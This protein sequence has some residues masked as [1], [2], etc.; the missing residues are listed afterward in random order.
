MPMQIMQTMIIPI[1]KNAKGLQTDKNNY[2]PIALTCI[3]SKVLETFILNKFVSN[4]VTSDF[5]FGFRPQ[6]ATD[7]CI[8]ALKEVIDFYTNNSS[9]LYIC[10]LDASKAFDKLNH[11]IL[12]DKLLSCYNIPVFIVRI[13]CYWFCMQQ[14]VVK[15][16]S[17]VSVPFSVLNGVRQGGIL[18]PLLFNIDID[19]L[20]DRLRSSKVGCHIGVTC[21]NLLFYAGDAVLL[22]PTPHSLQILVNICEEFCQANEIVY[23]AK[24]TVCMLFCPKSWSGVIEHPIYLYNRTL[25]Y[26]TNKKQDV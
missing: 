13:L 12:F 8:F 14:F 23:N 20:S 19:N 18:S 7:M 11:W 3:L 10:F 15:W 2:R 5:Q 6:H 9:P 16:A 24:K 1:I 4:L 26:F 17:V 21:F 25:N 22:A